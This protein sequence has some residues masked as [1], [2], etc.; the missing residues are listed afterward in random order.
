MLAISA[1]ALTPTELVNAILK[2]PVDL[3]YNGGIGTYVKAVVETHA[4]VGDR[5]N[6]ALRVNDHAIAVQGVGGGNFGCTQLGRISTRS[7]ADAS[8]PTRSTIPPASTRPITKLI[9]RSCSVGDCR[10]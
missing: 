3:I 10:R 5:A 7:A 4:Q 1:D 8:T 6:D 9:S 2:S